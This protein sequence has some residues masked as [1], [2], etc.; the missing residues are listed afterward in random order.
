[1]AGSRFQLGHSS[2][3]GEGEFFLR[4]SGTFLKVTYEIKWKL[5]AAQRTNYRNKAAEMV[6]PVTTRSGRI[7]LG[8][9]S[10]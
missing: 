1:V 7:A 2:K 9:N 8:D 6:S 3:I 4:Y 5:R 10:A